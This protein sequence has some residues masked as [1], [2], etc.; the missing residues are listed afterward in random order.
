MRIYSFATLQVSGYRTG[1]SGNVG[2]I[3]VS[4]ISTAL[5]SSRTE[6][7]VRTAS[8]LFCISTPVLCLF[9]VFAWASDQVSVT[10][11]FAVL[12]CGVAATIVRSR[13]LCYEGLQ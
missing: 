12:Y 10:P 2:A 11:L 8:T 9:L 6:N 5:H 7:Y 3:F 1:L 13:P 4:R